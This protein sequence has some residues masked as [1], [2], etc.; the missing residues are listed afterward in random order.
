MLEDL[1]GQASSLK[2]SPVDGLSSCFVE[3]PDSLDDRLILLHSASRAVAAIHPEHMMLR[4]G[5]EESP[6]IPLLNI[7]VPQ[8]QLLYA[9]QRQAVRLVASL[10][11]SYLMFLEAHQVLCV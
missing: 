4:R 11:L 10:T 2:L 7:R 5:E 9:Q 8:L 3:R 6:A 1:Q